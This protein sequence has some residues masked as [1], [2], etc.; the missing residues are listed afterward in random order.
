MDE[1]EDVF[2]KIAEAA[3]DGLQGSDSYAKDRLAL[4]RW[5]A[6][7]GVDKIQRKYKMPLSVTYR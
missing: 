6:E 7:K 1:I 4:I 2:I 5:L 3:K